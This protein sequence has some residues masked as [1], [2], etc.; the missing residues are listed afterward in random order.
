MNATSGQRDD[1]HSSNNLADNNSVLYTAGKIGNASRF[2]SANSEFLSLT[3]N[4]NISTGNID[5]SFGGWFRFT[6]IPGSSKDFYFKGA[7]SS[8]LTEYIMRKDSSQI[9]TFFV[10]GVSYSSVTASSHGAISNNTWYFLYCQHAATPAQISISINAGTLDTNGSTPPSDTTNPMYFGRG[11]TLYSDID[12]D[13]WFFYKRLLTQPEITW[14]YN[15]GAG[16]TYEDVAGPQPSALSIA[17]S[18][19]T[20]TISVLDRRIKLT[21][22]KRDTNLSTLTRNL[23]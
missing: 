23:Q 11:N 8:A 15:S 13:E 20:P 22:P 21:A 2:V 14:L 10:G 1:S 6:A 18:L 4:P 16:R 3:D 7:G 17:L 5:F 12:L 9:I 19:A